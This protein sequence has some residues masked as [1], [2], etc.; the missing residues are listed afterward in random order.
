MAKPKGNILFDRDRCKGCG[1]CLAVCPEQ[2]IYLDVNV[3]NSKGYHP[4]NISDYT[5]CTGCC[6]CALICPDVVITVE[7]LAA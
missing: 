2:I 7:R 1:L 4:A 5:K 3:T 6:S